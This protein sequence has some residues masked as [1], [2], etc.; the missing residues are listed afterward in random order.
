MYYEKI[1][2]WELRKMNGVRVKAETPS[3]K[4][5]EWEIT[6]ENNNVFILH[7][8]REAMGN[9]ADDAKWYKYSWRLLFSSDSDNHLTKEI[10]ILETIEEFTEWEEIYVSDES[11]D[12]ALNDKYK[13]IYICTSNSWKHIVQWPSAYN[14][15]SYRWFYLFKYIAKI[16]KEEPV[17][18]MTME[19]VCKA[20]GKKIKIIE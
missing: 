7:N 18:E 12:D 15:Q 11:V 13:M 9:D 1:T 10:N 8:N 16:P 2:A 6:V 14:N 20:L 17:E 5:I 19:Q 4:I 3:L